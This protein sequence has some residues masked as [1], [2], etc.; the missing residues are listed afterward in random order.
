MKVQGKVV[1]V[2]KE[3]RL[4]TIAVE[5]PEGVDPRQLREGFAFSTYKLG[6]APVV[7]SF[8]ARK[9]QGKHF[10]PDQWHISLQVEDTDTFE[11]F[12]VG[13]EVEFDAN[14]HD[15]AQKADRGDPT[16]FA[17]LRHAFGLNGR[18]MFR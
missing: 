17:R 6:D 14:V 3:T 9:D 10:L 15:D 12:E 13:E 4:V 7:E 8:I 1:E 16:G 11:K 18:R 5:T 2:V